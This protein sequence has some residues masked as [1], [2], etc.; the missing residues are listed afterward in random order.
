MDHGQIGTYLETE[1]GQRADRRELVRIRCCFP[2][3]THPEGEQ[4][5][6]V[7]DVARGLSYLNEISIVHGDLK[8][9][10]LP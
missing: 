9:V 10:C 3:L 1:A 2:S 5:P 6:Q 8:C 7:M 4:F